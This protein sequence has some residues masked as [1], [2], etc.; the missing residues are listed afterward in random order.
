MA[1]GSSAEQRGA[2]ADAEQ[3]LGERGHPNV[4]V[5]GV[6][7]EG[8]LTEIAFVEKGRPKVARIRAR[9]GS[10]AVLVEVTEGW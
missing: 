9:P 6:D 2:E 5:Y 1:A 3:L 8:E 7:A 10:A 4:R